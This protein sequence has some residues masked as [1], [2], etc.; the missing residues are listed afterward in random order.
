MEKNTMPLPL[1]YWPRAGAGII[2]LML[3][4]LC[5][6]FRFPE[7]RALAKLENTKWVALNITALITAP[8][9]LAV[10]ASSFLKLHI[11]P[12]GIDVT[13]FG[14][15]L[16][17][18][19]AERI[20]I[21]SAVQYSRKLDAV[22]QIA[23][24]LVPVEEMLRKEQMKATEETRIYYYIYRKSRYFR[25]NL[26]LCRDVLW[27]D[28]SAERAKLLMDMYPHARWVDG[29]PDHRFDKQLKN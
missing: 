9:F 4:A 14:M 18:V 6:V 10:G 19:P 2:W 25:V 27:L 29:S 8:L 21:I 24:C 7:I 13:L 3:A 1:K 17:Y 16:R 11:Q 26:N 20:H 5:L 22:D 12:E 23:L 28:W 15:T